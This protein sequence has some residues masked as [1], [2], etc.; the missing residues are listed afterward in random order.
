MLKAIGR[1]ENSA[2][3]AGANLPRALT[4]R[5]GP[6]SYPDCSMLEVNP[7]ADVPTANLL[8]VWKRRQPGCTPTGV[9][10]PT[11]DGNRNCAFV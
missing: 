4:I 3:C 2:C 8:R 11:D 5:N 10:D 1:L 9:E 7:A 6:E